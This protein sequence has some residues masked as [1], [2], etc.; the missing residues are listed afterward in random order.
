MDTKYIYTTY[1]LDFLKKLCYERNL[2]SNKL[3]K[4]QICDLLVEN[5]LIFDGLSKQKFPNITETEIFELNIF[6]NL[7][8]PKIKHNFKKIELIHTA[9]ASIVFKSNNLILKMQKKRELNSELIHEFLISFLYINEIT[10][11][12]PNFIKSK[13]I[14]YGK[15]PKIDKT[16]KVYEYKDLFNPKNNN[17][18]YLVYENCNDSIT[19]ENFVNSCTLSDFMLSFLQ[20]L[21]SLQIAYELYDFKHNDLH[22]KNVLIKKNLDIKSIKYLTNFGNYNIKT[23]GNISVIID[24]GRSAVV[25]NGVKFIR[26]LQHTNPVYDILKLLIWLFYTFPEKLKTETFELFTY[27][28][29]VNIEDLGQNL[30]KARD[31]YIPELYNFNLKDYILFCLDFCEKNNIEYIYK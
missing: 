25:D 8:K 10:N 22:T 17:I 27:F 29:N 23:N 26:F 9:S 19:L 5:L 13:G 28:F 21:F 11:Y 12:I 4:S 3:N 16:K 24:Y 20:V 1:K 18:L 15:Y 31:F 14:I 7:T 6:N 30:K 2:N